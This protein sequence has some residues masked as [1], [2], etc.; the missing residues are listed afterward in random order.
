[1][2]DK[3]ILGIIL[4]FFSQAI[5]AEERADRYLL[6]EVFSWVTK[7]GADELIETAKRAKFNVIVPIVWH[8][9]GVSWLDEEASVFEPA[10]VNAN[11]EAGYDAF[12][13]LLT[14]AK[15]NNLK[16][17]PW[18]TVSLR[19]IDIY[20]QFY[21]EGTPAKA[22]DIHNIQ[23]REFM[24]GLI[25]RFAKKYQV[26][27]VGL[28]FVR[29]MGECTSLN[30]INNYKDRFGRDLLRD[31]K[32]MML[33][34]NARNTIQM[35]NGH[36][37][38]EIIY[39]VRAGLKKIDDSMLLNVMSHA[40]MEILKDQGANSI[41]WAN[42]DAVDKILHIEYAK[43]G[44]F[45]DVLINT[46]LTNLEDK[47]KFVLMVGNYDKSKEG[48]VSRDEQYVGELIKLSLCVDNESDDAALYQYIYLNSFQVEA[49]S[50]S[51]LD[52]DKHGCNEG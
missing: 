25:L 36:A 7:E 31:Q 10:W 16:V 18:F 35:W 13:Y 48:P 24:I 21:D 33:D 1:M 22:F 42:D 37:I 46:A 8:G 40:G 41:K 44:K 52:Y 19:V 2:I 5:W 26:D 11:N 15:K 9:R 29:S 43:P 32:M 6:D 45:R 38:D 3:K 23:F 39:S 50:N 34:S 51:F 27:G 28:D 17:H 49:I 20:S 47:S 14:A 4:L 12:G 30:C